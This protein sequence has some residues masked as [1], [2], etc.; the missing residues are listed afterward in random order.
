MHEM[1]TTLVLDT[2][3]EPTYGA[4]VI[5][6]FGLSVDQWVGHPSYDELA[7]GWIPCCFEPSSQIK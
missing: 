4:V 5:L 7:Y 2:L 6:E 1:N 3:H